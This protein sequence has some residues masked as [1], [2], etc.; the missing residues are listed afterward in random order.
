MPA[1][2]IMRLVEAART[3]AQVYEEFFVPAMF[4]P[5]ARELLDVVPPRPGE[6]ALDVACGSGVVARMVAERVGPD[7]RVVGV[8]LRPPM[9]AVAASLPAPPGAEI[10]WREGD[11]LAL[12]F[13]DA[14]FDLV[15]C[16]QGL[17]FFPDQEEA[18]GEMRR[19]VTPGGRV[20]LAVWQGF[21]R[22]D[23]L[24]ALTEVEARHLSVLGVPYEELA[25]PFLFGDP[26][27]L[28]DLAAGAGFSDVRVEERSFE[29]RFPAD[30]FIENV[31]FAY[32]A[33]VPQF[34]EDP[35]AFDEFVQ[36]VEREVRDVLARHRD[37]DQI[38]FPL[39]VNLAAARG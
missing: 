21:D 30:G 9:L 17:Q 12:D 25:G 20:G 34:S 32:S 15:L 39:H 16:Q 3:P 13:A 11:A 31:E 2:W 36:V 5:C 29:A 22:N 27:W 33:V 1:R 19:V 14:S 23:V 18:V 7:G 6:R 24:G 26:H 38:V 4:A 8:D 28:R 10:E 37:G 35:A